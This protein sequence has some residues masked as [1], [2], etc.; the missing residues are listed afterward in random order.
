MAIK[1]KTIRVEVGEIPK[2]KKEGVIYFSNFEEMNKVLNSRRIELLEIIKREKPDSIYHL[3]SLVN[4]DQGNVTKDVN[5]LNKHGFIEIIKVKEG[6]R[7]KSEP[8]LDSEGIEMIIKL[9]AG[10]FGLA[11]E[12]FEQV[13]KEFKDD[14]LKQNTEQV[15]KKYK[16]L[17]KPLKKTVKKVAKKFD[18]KVEE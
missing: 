11:K 13:S 10:A 9:G 5:L 6:N 4:R 14:N 16:N 18:I 15:K 8:T 2:K 17:I 12:T 1:A 3:A 7:T